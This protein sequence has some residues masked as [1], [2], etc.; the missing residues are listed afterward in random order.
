MDFVNIK[1][2]FFHYHLLILDTKYI[3]IKMGKIQMN[4]LCIN[5]YWVDCMASFQI[6]KLFK[7]ELKYKSLFY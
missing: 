4:N 6:T 1:N 2:K 5:Y 7:W 3:F